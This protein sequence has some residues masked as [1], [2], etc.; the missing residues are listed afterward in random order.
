MIAIVIMLVESAVSH[1][2]VATSAAS[3]HFTLPGI[4]EHE[5]Q[6]HFEREEICF[7]E[8]AMVCLCPQRCKFL[9]PEL[10]IG[11]SPLQL[12]QETQSAIAQQP[13]FQTKI[14]DLGFAQREVTVFYAP[15]RQQVFKTIESHLE[16]LTDRTGVPS[17]KGKIG[18]GSMAN[19]AGVRNQIQVI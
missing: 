11:N 6:M 4:P 9:L 12:F 13:L 16:V 10:V 18:E 3:S 15:Q 14:V 5:S 1:V 8:P 17:W 19:H 2:V 7:L